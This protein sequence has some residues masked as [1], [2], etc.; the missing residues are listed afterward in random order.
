MLT[1][2]LLMS[3]LDASVAWPTTLD[4]PLVPGWPRIGWPDAAVSVQALLPT[5]CNPCRLEKSA[6]TI[7]PTTCV[8][9]LV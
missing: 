5:G 3:T 7:V 2:S 8:S 6:S 4:R 9:P 1:S